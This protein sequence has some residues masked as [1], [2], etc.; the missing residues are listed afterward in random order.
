MFNK[1]KSWYNYFKFPMISVDGLSE[2]LRVIGDEFKIDK[3]R[4]PAMSK[5]STEVRF[6]KVAQICEWNLPCFNPE[7]RIIAH[8]ALCYLHEV[9]ADHD[10]H[11]EELEAADLEEF[12]TVELDLED[13]D[14]DDLDTEY[15]DILDGVSE[16]ESGMTKEEDSDYIFLNDGVKQRE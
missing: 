15:F 12:L 7:D 6:R 10:A 11:M 14:A 3:L 13:L 1:L 8:I 2:E 9:I 16:D 5:D 4:E